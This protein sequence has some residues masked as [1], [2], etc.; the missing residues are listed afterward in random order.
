VNTPIT[1][2]DGKVLYAL[3]AGTH[4]AAAP[5]YSNMSLRILILLLCLSLAKI[6]IIKYNRKDPSKFLM[7]LVILTLFFIILNTYGQV[8]GQQSGLALITM[9]T[10]LKLF[11]IKS[12]R[13][14]YIVIYSSFFIIA[15][16][17][18]HSQSVW[19][20]LYV[21]FV[22]L[23]L[24][25]TLIALSDRLKTTSLKDRFKIS[26]RFIFLATPL[27]IIL[28]F[29]FPRLPGPLWALPNDA[30]SSQTGLS[31]E[32]SPGSINRLISSSAIAFRVKFEDKIPT[33]PERYW[34]GVVLSAYDGKTWRRH[35]AP[36][37]TK[38]NI[39]FSTDDN[40]DVHYQVTLEPNNLKWLVSLD[41]PLDYQSPY[42]FSREAMLL[43]SKTISN[44]ISYKINS[45]TSAL[46]QSLFPEESYKNRLLPVNLNPQTL[47]FSRQLLASSDYDTKKYINS[48]LAYFGSNN[49]I[50]TLSPDLLG[51][52]AMDD[53]L[54]N[55]Q[56]G[57]CEHYASA[58]VYLARAAGIPARVVIGYQGGEMNPLDNYMIVRQ[59]DAHAWAEI[60]IDNFWMRIDPTAAVSPDRVEQGV[61]NAGLEQDKLPFFLISNSTTIRNITYL[62]DSFQNSWNN[63]I[64]GF[65]QEKQ[66]D[67]LEFL[68]FEDTGTSNLILLLVS[69]MSISGLIITWLL[70]KQI[71]V[72]NDRIQHYYDLYCQK[73]KRHGMQR[74]LNEGPQDFENRLY[75]ELS[76][77]E[78]TRKNMAFIFKAYRSLHYGNQTNESLRKRYF[79]KVKT[80]KVKK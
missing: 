15:S 3:L 30:F 20:F 68:G 70:L 19:L 12:N 79:K 63:W 71:T 38:P 23:F 16:S 69:L 40:N 72:S 2:P 21:F 11:E 74:R 32:M 59:S 1:K 26:S 5:F 49:F 66:E 17:F 10:T 47:K 73:L 28:F 48:V 56:K 64:V 54:F 51:T 53:F 37:K 9:M 43:S 65:D 45:Q 34:R 35:D 67:L 77:S 41:Y 7:M 75:N 25:S 22:V 14:C 80:F 24:L 55:T 36:R 4:L 57:F 78:Q 27:M 6:F 33:Q 8:F 60:W 46:N 61:L 52:H 44:V 18:F 58:F 76:L 29:L 62:Y 42:H 31:E 50:Y 13:D 39:Q